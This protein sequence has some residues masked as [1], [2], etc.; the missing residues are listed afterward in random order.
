MNYKVVKNFQDKYSKEYYGINAVYE[1]E[2]TERAAELE[3]GGFIVP[4]EIQANQANQAN[5]KTTQDVT[6]TQKYTIVNGEKVE[7]AA[8]TEEHVKAEQAQQ[9]K[10]DQ[11]KADQQSKAQEAQRAQEAEQTKA[12]AKTKTQ[13]AKR[14]R[15]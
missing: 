5:Q 6:K 8:Q 11:A 7:V 10:A 9:A 1:T 15:Q 13:E 3:R 14:E 2:N 12:K 4:E